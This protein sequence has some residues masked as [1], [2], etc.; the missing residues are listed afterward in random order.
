[1]NKNLL[2][3]VILLTV[4]LFTM[5]CSDN[6][7]D[8]SDEWIDPVFAR[9]L[10]ERGYIRDAKTVTPIDVESLSEINVS[11]DL[12]DNHQGYIESLRGIE[13]FTSL[14]YLECSNNRLTWLDV[15]NNTELSHIHCQGNRLESINVSNCLR[16]LELNCSN[17]N[18]RGLNI[19]SNTQLLN[20]ICGENRLEE[21]D[22]SYC[23]QLFSVDCRNNRLT[24]LNVLNNRQLVGLK[25]ENNP[26]VN[27]VFEVTAWFDGASIPSKNFTHKDWL[28]KGEF[29]TVKYVKAQ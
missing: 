7:E 15:G 26:G 13:Y 1:M 21:L 4:S 20:L 19:S 3:C 29:V 28:Y 25:C 22:V 2:H 27:G 8:G 14:T 24:E 23:P 6:Q 12:S 17:N 9:V 16:L 18:L 5:G 11:G 10:Q